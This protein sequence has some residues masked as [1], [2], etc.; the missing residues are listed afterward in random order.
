MSI[1]VGSPI[2]KCELGEMFV[3]NRAKLRSIAM[4]IVGSA[5]EAD[6]VV[7]EAYLKVVGACSYRVDKPYNY[8]CQ[9]V[10]NLAFDFRRRR[11]VEASY[12]VYTDDGELPPVHSGGDPS[13]SVHD[14][15]LLEAIEQA[16]A[17]LP[18]R[19]RRIFELYRLSG[20]TQREIARQQG[21]SATLVNFILKDAVRAL[22]A[23]QYRLD[24][25]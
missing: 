19:T 25:D 8:C 17:A 9:I 5:D 3:A 16:L 6:D 22:M 23:C 12:R 10:R 1:S 21:C 11:A 2:K 20:M 15:R 14:R 7:Q 4:K 18:E 24:G 13:Q